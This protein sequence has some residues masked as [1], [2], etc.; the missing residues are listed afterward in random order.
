MATR[1]KKEEVAE[2]QVEEVKKPATR[3]RRKKAE[4]APAEEAEQPVQSSIDREVTPEDM[5]LIGTWQAAVETLAQAKIEEAA[6]RTRV[7]TTF[8]PDV[9]NA[10]SKEGTFHFTLPEG[11]DLELNT[12]LYSSIDQAA[13]PAVIEQLKEM[14][15]ETDVLF[16]YVPELAIR[17]FRKLSAEAKA[18]LSQAVSQSRGTPQI[19]VKPPKTTEEAAPNV[20]TRAK[21]WYVHHESGCIFLDWDGEEHD[22]HTVV[23]TEAEAKSLY[24]THG[25]T[26]SGDA[27]AS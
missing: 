21:V 5:E 23:I 9:A 26:Y 27:T 15:V 11:W 7:F 6:L 25:Y 18:V 3:S 10:P 19:K 4:A 8:F 12:K 2:E 16:R 22:G 14:E 13:L 1:K 20:E 24:D 17:P